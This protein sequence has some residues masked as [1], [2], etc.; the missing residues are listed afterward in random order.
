MTKEDDFA[1]AYANLKGPRKKDYIGTAKALQR[2]KSYPEY[3]TNEKLAQ[4][5]PVTREMVRQF[6]TLLRLPEEIQRL[7]GPDGLKLEHG[8]RLWQ[9]TRKR[10]D[11]QRDVTRAMAEL[12]AHDARDLVTYVLDHA[13]MPVMEARKIILN[14][15]TKTTREY[16]VIAL[17]PESEYKSLVEYARKQRLPV[18]AAVTSI[19]RSW[20]ASRSE[21][22]D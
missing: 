5:L 1:I 7:F 18:D 6:L 11:L 14:S 8:R 13:D 15:K 3:N 21:F 9:V 4:Q 19:I 2:L 22:G 20:L 17:L 10:P 12:K 16:H